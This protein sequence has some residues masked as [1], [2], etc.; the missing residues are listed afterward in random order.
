MMK[1][2]RLYP[3][4][5]TSWCCGRESCDGCADK[6]VLDEWNA[7]VER[8]GAVCEDEI[9]SPRVYSVPAKNTLR[10]ER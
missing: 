3:S 7:W 10:G 8:T 5:C 9:W 2:S 6:Q 4:C 1:N